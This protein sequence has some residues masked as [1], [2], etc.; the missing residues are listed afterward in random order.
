MTVICAILLRGARQ[1]KVVQMQSPR[2]HS[3][4]PE[5]QKKARQYIF[6]TIHSYTYH[7]LTFQIKFVLLI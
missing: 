7:S 6:Y 2:D 3:F 5:T 4:K 1:S